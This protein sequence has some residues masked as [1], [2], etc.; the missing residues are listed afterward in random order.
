MDVKIWSIILKEARRLSVSKQ[1]AEEN[2]LFGTKRKE[3]T[4]MWINLHT[5][6]VDVDVG[7]LGCNAV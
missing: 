7:L 6:D 5:A 1:S 3:A 4:G 2:S